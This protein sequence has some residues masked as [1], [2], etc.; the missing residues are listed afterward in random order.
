MKLS[1]L[2]IGDKVEDI[3]VVLDKPKYGYISQ[4][5]KNNISVIDN[6]SKTIIINLG[7][8]EKPIEW[9]TDINH[10]EKTWILVK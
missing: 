3:T 10:Y 1:D 5:N 4:I 9:W 8:K 7:T 6:V 2:E